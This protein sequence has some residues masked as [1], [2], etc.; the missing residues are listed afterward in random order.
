MLRNV[1][2]LKRYSNNIIWTHECTFHIL[3]FIGSLL[4]SNISISK[5]PYASFVC[6]LLVPK[7]FQ[8][9]IQFPIGRIYF[10]RLQNSGAKLF[11]IWN[12]FICWL[13]WH[14]WVA[15]KGPLILTFIPVLTFAKCGVSRIPFLA[16]TNVASRCISASCILMTVAT[17]TTLV[18]IYTGSVDKELKLN[19]FFA[20]IHLSIFLINCE[21]AESYGFLEYIWLCDGR[22]FCDIQLLYDF[23]LVFLYFW[24]KKKLML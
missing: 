21:G 12:V 19:F 7:S 24:M 15:V 4:T 11:R 17:N 13:F 1:S 9:P 5:Y 23:I 10:N 22:F 2:I 20:L 14:S 16:C 8:S 3:P 6:T 18:Q